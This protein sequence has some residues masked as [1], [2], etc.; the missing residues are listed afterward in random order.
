MV[1][2]WIDPP[3]RIC[4][5][6]AA[7]NNCSALLNKLLATLRLP[8]N[9]QKL[10]SDVSGQALNDLFQM[11]DDIYNQLHPMTPDQKILEPL[12]V[13]DPE[14]LRIKVMS[15]ECD[16]NES[17][18]IRQVIENYLHEIVR[19]RPNKGIDHV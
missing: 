12:R 16:D 3:P 6:D 14:I 19:L 13:C 4:L 15:M 11:A 17:L 7:D 18:A 1:D 10:R 5:S 8:R 9:R 2:N